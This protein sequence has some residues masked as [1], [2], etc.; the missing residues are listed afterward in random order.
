MASYHYVMLDIIGPFKGQHSIQRDIIKSVEFLSH[1]QYHNR[2]L[3][4]KKNTYL[5]K[6]TP[7]K[8]YH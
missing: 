1:S 3:F 7:N 4:D 2:I 5:A 6:E 8:T